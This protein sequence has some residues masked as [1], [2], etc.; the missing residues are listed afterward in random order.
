MDE[1]TY[2]VDSR[3][4]QEKRS[5]E[6]QNAL[7][8]HKYLSLGIAD[9]F[10]GGHLLIDM[11]LCKREE[12]SKPCIEVCSTNALHWSGDGKMMIFSELCMHCGACVLVCAVENCIEITRKRSCGKVE[13]LSSAKQVLAVHRN[14]STT[15]RRQRVKDRSIDRLQNQIGKNRSVLP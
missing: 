11:K 9:V 7:F 1:N 3:K 4:E 15:K 12:C 13:T 8:Q 6:K 2:V 10:L 5:L 14:T